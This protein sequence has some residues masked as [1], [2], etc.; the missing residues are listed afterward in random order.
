VAQHAEKRT[1][2]PR[3]LVKAAQTPHGRSAYSDL[4]GK[5][6]DEFV[7]NRHGAGP[8]NNYFRNWELAGLTVQVT[9]FRTKASVA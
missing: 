1:K 5:A 9:Y 7:L 4:F 8:Q 2:S 6:P 3:T